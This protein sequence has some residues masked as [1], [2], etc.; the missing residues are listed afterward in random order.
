MN[1]ATVQRALG[2]ALLGTA[3]LVIAAA[4]VLVVAA[5]AAGAEPSTTPAGLLEGG[6][7]RSDGAA[8]GL[9]GSPLMILLGVV[10]LGV[11]TALVTLV[12]AR[13]TRR[14]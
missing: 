6:D 13:L 14:A 2:L 5:V 12:V 9:V 11:A 7:P 1:G 8:P 10:A 3:I 4:A